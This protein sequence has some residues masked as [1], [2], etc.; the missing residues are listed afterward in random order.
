MAWEEDE[1]LIYTVVVNHEEQ[2]SIWPEYKE[3]PKGWRPV[4]KTGLKAECLAYIKRRLDRYA[5]SQPPQADGG[6][7]SRRSLK[8]DGRLGGIL[9]GALLYA[10]PFVPRRSA[11]PIY[12]WVCATIRDRRAGSNAIAGFTAPR[13]GAN[14]GSA[15]SV[16]F[17]VDRVDRLTPDDFL[18]QFVRPRRPVIV[19]GGLKNC[20]AYSLWNLDYLRCCSADRV[21]PVKKWDG[22]GIHLEEVPLH[23]Y[24][25]DLQDY[26]IQMRKRR[27]KAGISPR[28]SADERHSRRCFGYRGADRIFSRMVWR[29]VAEICAAFPRSV[30]KRDAV[31]LRLPLDA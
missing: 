4:G 17:T 5:A 2:Y 21:V 16:D 18:E 3:I 9:E 25:D 28:R 23:Q 11:A 19:A 12:C 27:S 7:R 15:M 30:G 29:A 22:S 14:S 1:S 26:R 6:G 8:Q 20:G 24:L 31:T 13:F 10:R